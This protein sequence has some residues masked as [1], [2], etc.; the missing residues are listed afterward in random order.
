LLDP[1]AADTVVSSSGL[2]DKR[3][4]ACDKTGVKPGSIAQLYAEGILSVC[5]FYVES[6]LHCAADITKN[7]LKKHILSM[8]SCQQSLRMNLPIK[9][10]L[11]AAML[12]AAVLPATLGQNYAAAQSATATA[13]DIVGTWQGTLHIAQANR[14]LRVVIKIAKADGGYKTTFYSIDQGSQ[15]IVAS[16]TSFENGELKFSI[17]VASANY[18]GKTSADGKT[19]AGNWKQGA[20]SLPLNLTRATADTEW[21]IQEPL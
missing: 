14:D 10:L 13:Q 6:P 3:E 19:I 11:A 21:A 8:M 4:R 5:K 17:D 15:S 18:E 9:L 16:K 1:V 20:S 7:D 12:S 2:F